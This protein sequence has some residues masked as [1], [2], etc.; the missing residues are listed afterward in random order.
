MTVRCRRIVWR[1][2]GAE[3]I[4]D[5]SKG[6][7]GECRGAPGFV[8]SVGN[9]AVRHENV[10]VGAEFS[11]CGFHFRPGREPRS[12]RAPGSSPVRV[13]R[14]FAGRHRSM[15]RAAWRR[16]TGADKLAQGGGTPSPSSMTY[17]MSRR[18]LARQ[19]AFFGPSRAWR[20]RGRREAGRWS[21]AARCP[22]QPGT[23]KRC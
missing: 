15:C 18:R 8:R 11:D 14:A 4:G 20:D 17:C 3:A 22:R 13:F 1:L 9:F 21:R 5:F 10:E 12:G 23:D 16:R 6:G 7:A 2:N 19:P